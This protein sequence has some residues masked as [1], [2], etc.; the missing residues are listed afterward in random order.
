[1]SKNKILLIGIIS[2][3][4]IVILFFVINNKSN[5][6]NEVDKENT[7]NIEENI[8]KDNES[9]NNHENKDDSNSNNNNNNNDIVGNNDDEFSVDDKIDELNDSNSDNLDGNLNNEDSNTSNNNGGS[10]NSNNGKDDKLND[11]NQSENNVSK[12]NNGSGNNKS[13]E[14]NKWKNINEENEVEDGPF[15]LNDLDRLF[16][17]KI[18][19]TKSFN[20]NDGNVKSERHEKLEANTFP[21]KDIAFKSIIINKNYINNQQTIKA[22][23]N[24]SDK[25][26]L[27]NIFEGA[28]ELDGFNYDNNS[29]YVFNL[30]NGEEGTVVKMHF[31]IDKG[32]NKNKVIVTSMKNSTSGVPI[33]TA[34]ELTKENLEAFYSLVEN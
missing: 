10:S 9:V 26:K 13:W 22:T 7:N 29:D 32:N 2:L 3:L 23:Y 11:N 28:I 30:T 19:M 18:V 33:N 14:N 20:F 15:A 24:P 17:D 25:N 5:K 8:S 1:M 31:W 16:N 27:A 6:I 4:F 12:G 21:V 34:Y